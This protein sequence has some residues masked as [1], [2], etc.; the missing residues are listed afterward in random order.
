MSLYGIGFKVEGNLELNEC[1]RE[2]LVSGHKV[3]LLVVLIYNKTIDRKC[4]CGGKE[5]NDIF[6]YL[7]NGKWVL[8][9]PNYG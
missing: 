1:N 9:V 5:H 2:Y 6:E 7:S 8:G 4:C 3:T